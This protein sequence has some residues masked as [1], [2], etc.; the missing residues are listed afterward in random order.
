MPKMKPAV[1]LLHSSMSSKAQWADLMSQLEDGFRCIAV[2]LL[3]YGASP[4]PADVDAGYVHTLAHEVDAVNAA[5]ASRL[6]PGEAFHLI[7]HSFGGAS[8]L[9]MARRMPGRVLSLTLFEPVAFH[10]LPAQHPAR[11][12]IAGVVERI[13]ACGPQQDRDATRIFI[14]YWNRAGAFD[15]APPAAQDKMTGMIAKVRLD[16]QA[17]LGE[18]ATMD[19]L[20]ALTMPSLVMYGA[21][22]PAS[23][24]LLAEALAAA[25]PSATVLQTRGAHMAPITHGAVVNPAIVNFLADAEVTA[26]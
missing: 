4:F 19:D 18:A 17:L 6:E 25:L 9:H 23:T 11:A 13:N 2:D 16:F 14:D 15:A 12:E 5:I 20:S 10:L 1:V 26:D 7:G 22:S 21:H 24:S 3:G 8:A